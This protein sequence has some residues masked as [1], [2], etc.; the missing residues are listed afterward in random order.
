MN[1][2][3]LQIW[4]KRSFSAVLTCLFVSWAFLYCQPLAV[5]DSDADCKSRGF[6]RCLQGSCLLLDES[7]GSATSEG[8][9]K[10]GS[11]SQDDSSGESEDTKESVADN[12]S[13][14]PEASP[15]S[16]VEAKPK[17]PD[18]VPNLI[19]HWKFDEESGSVA[20]DSSGKGHDGTI[21]NAVRLNVAGRDGKAFQFDGTSESYVSVVASLLP[22]ESAYTASFWLKTAKKQVPLLS[23]GQPTKDDVQ[24]WSVEIYGKNEIA[25]LQQGRGTNGAKVV[26]DDKWHFIVV[27]RDTSGQVSIYVDGSED[28][29]RKE[30]QV[31]ALFP[32][33]EVGRRSSAT[34]YFYTGLID[35]VRLYDVALS[36]TK[37]KQL[38]QSYSG[39]EVHCYI[40]T[41]CSPN[42]K[43]DVREAVGDTCVSARQCTHL[44]RCKQAALGGSCLPQGTKECVYSAGCS[45]DIQACKGGSC[46]PAS[47]CK[48]AVVWYSLKPGGGKNQCPKE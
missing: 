29:S 4:I 6:G 28:I 43:E 7:G 25:L 47:E 31:P 41:T 15:E 37:V 33:L 5:C 17:E 14:L 10:D 20:K 32:G 23:N 16:T 35:D 22:A 9:F 3:S 45:S 1:T 27:T 48:D 30:S 42:G 34:S 12:V 36:S 19:L 39:K 2:L 21:H 18:V 44:W 26:T 8:S 46:V 13:T 24:G 11:T 38:Y 40:D